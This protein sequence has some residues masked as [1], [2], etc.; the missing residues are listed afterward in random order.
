MALKEVWHHFFGRVETATRNTVLKTLPDA[1][2]KTCPLN[3][4]SGTGAGVVF[5]SQADNSLREFLRHRSRQGLER[6]L[7]V[8]IS[9]DKLSS[10]MVWSLLQ[11]GASDVMSLRHSKD[12]GSDIAARIK[13]WQTIDDVLL[14]PLVKDNLVGQSPAW[15]CAL[16]QVIEIARFTDSAILIT[17][18][19]GTGKEMIARLI[20][21]LDSQRCKRNLVVLDCTTVVPELSGSE[22]FG[23]ERGAFTTAIAQ[24]E[25][26]FSLADGGTL[27][28]DEVGELPLALQAELLR[29]VQE[30]TFKRV[31]SNQW[32]RTDFR[33]IC[34]TNRNLLEQEVRGE[35]RR[36]FYHRIAS[37][38]CHL[39]SLAQRVEDILPLARHFFQQICADR[40]APQFD[41]AVCE[42]LIQ[43]SY[44]GNVRELRQLITRIACHHVGDGLVTAG[45]V[46]ESDRPALDLESSDWRD[47]G[48]ERSIRRALVS[49]ANLKEI[50]RSAEEAAERLALEETEGNVARAA[51]KLGV[52]ERTLQMHRAARRQNVAAVSGNG[53]K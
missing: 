7:A 13:R 44:P 41:D 29:V 45:D 43:R 32:Q 8:S 39:P 22:F 11:A 28:L 50:T 48:F 36:D 47:D 51:Q 9:P 34:A 53:S 12:T 1:G 31:G 21:T 20:H 46:P 42:Y 16:R 15:T 2:V 19:S 10:Q 6:V 4:D 17:G 3:P 33:L 38:T 37:W 35:F 23:H 25:G 26:A 5:F 52:N 27:F 24:R 18:E 49:G 40:E 30:K 14:S